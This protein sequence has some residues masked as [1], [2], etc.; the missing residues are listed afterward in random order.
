LLAGLLIS[1]AGLLTLGNRQINSG[2]HTSRALAVA[3]S[4]VEGLELEAYRQTHASLGCDATL[5][6]CRVGSG[7]ATVE[8]WHALAL[9]SLPA[10]RV[11]IRIDAIGAPSL[12]AAP[13]LRITVAVSWREGPRSRRL[14]LTTLRV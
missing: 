9:A 12:D 10:P 4:I 11:E 7:Q 14:R 5:P 8:G 1:V 13:A 2:A 6:T 3:R